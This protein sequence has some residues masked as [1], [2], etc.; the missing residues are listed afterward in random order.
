MKKIGLV[1]KETSENDIKQNIKT[2]ESLIVIKYSGLSSIDLTSLRQALTA[3]RARMLVVKNSVARR[4]LKSSGLEHI[5]KLI[6]GPCGLV[7]VKDEPVDASKALFN[8]AKDHDKLKLEGGVFK[9]R[10]LEKKDIEALARLPSKEVLRAQVTI[11]LKSPINGLVFVLK[12]NLRKLV[13][14]LDQIKNKKSS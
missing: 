4:A 3:S 7:F 1:V 11:T 8:F 13:I 6:E 2:S 5:I 12:G 14:C 10:V 9:D